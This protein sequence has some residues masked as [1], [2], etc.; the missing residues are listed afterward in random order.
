MTIWLVI[1][2][3]EYEG[4]EIVACLASRE[5]AEEF[6]KLAELGTCAE[7]LIQDY[8]IG[9]KDENIK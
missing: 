5:E 7:I 2:Y 3:W 1:K 8:P 4:Q 9:W 6:A